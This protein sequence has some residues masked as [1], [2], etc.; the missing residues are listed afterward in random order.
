MDSAGGRPTPKA[1]VQA[2]HFSG[3]S[4][5]YA[6]FRPRYPA[7]LFAY[8]AGLAPARDVAW[9][10]GTGS[11]QAAVTLAEHFEVVIATDLS[12]EQVAHATPHPR[13]RYL[14]AAAERS[15]VADASVSLVTVAQALHWFDPASFA[16]E[17][18]R[19]LRPSGVLAAW[20]YGRVQ[21]DGP[22]VQRVLDAFYS[23]T[24]GRY[25]P[26]ERRLVEEGYRSLALPVSE[27][28]APCFRM[29]ADLTLGELLGYVGTW[30]ATQRHRRATGE[31]P[32]PALARELSREW[33][34]EDR[35]RAVRWPLT[36]RVGIREA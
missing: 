12:A 22:S 28:E 23:G 19:V 10:C 32:L 1:S 4:A 31:D 13:V 20:G 18:R 25:W 24:V 36:L 8:L 26:A 17:V 15:G 3:V 9:D 33:G 14:V 21:V 5:D 2:G 30:S 27:R 34:E 35:R 11:G 29:E 16:Q 7:D 6:R